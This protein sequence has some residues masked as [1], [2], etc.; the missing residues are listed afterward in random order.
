MT[1]STV[2]NRGRRHSIVALTALALAV[3]AP[4]CSKSLVLPP[5]A[6]ATPAVGAI[7]PIAECYDE[8]AGGA[9]FGYTNDNTSPVVIPANDGNHLSGDDPGDNPMLTTLFAPGQVTH[10]F[11]ARFGG[12]TSLVWSLT[13]PDGVTRTATA[14]G[15]FDDLPFCELSITVAGDTRQPVVD[16]TGTLSDDGT[17]VTFDISLTG[18]PP[19]SVCNSAFQAEPVLVGLGDGSALPTGYDTTR[20]ATVAL[21]DTLAADDGGTKLAALP[22]VALVVDQ[23]SY[24]GTTVTSWPSSSVVSAQTFGTVFCAVLAEDGTLTT[25]Q[26]PNYCEGPPATGGSPIRPH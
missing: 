19:T 15:T 6:G 2:R 21:H 18:V 4:A 24:D 16:G 14:D 9:Y 12:D 26:T 8:I 11:L 13:G 7:T 10:A 1:E 3:L 5:T 23:C 20:T 17:S 22:V 25:V